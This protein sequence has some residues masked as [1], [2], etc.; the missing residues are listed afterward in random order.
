[1]GPR[2][3][4]QHIRKAYRRLLHPLIRILMRNGFSAPETQELVR[5]VFVDAATYD[6]F[7]GGNRDLS[8]GRVAIITG[9]TRR[10]VERLRSGKGL[11]SIDSSLSRIQ[12]LIAGWNQDPMFTGPYGLPLA[13]TFEHDVS[14]GD[15]PSFCEL[16]EKHGGGLPARAMLDELLRTGLAVQEGDSELIRNTGRTY[17]PDQMDPAAIERFGKVV[18]RLADTL[19]YNNQGKVTGETRFER[20]AITD[21]GLTRDQYRRFDAFLRIKCQELLETIDNWLAD[22]EGRIEP[23][24]ID[25][26]S[27]RTNIHTGIG[28]YHFL[29][30]RLSF[31]DD[32]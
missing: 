23:D 5:Q 30:R 31:E 8:D 9:L 4:K 2:E 25:E 19:D 11:A 3:F 20:A 18:A 26:N 14:A 27:E 6:E 1:M 10:E 13:L 24:E 16:V 21:I 29:D 12:R 15:T 28:V 32:E 7:G 22:E 17:I